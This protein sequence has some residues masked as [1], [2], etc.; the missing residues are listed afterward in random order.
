MHRYFSPGKMPVGAW[1]GRLPYKRGSQELDSSYRESFSTAKSDLIMASH[2]E[3]R[4][5]VRRD[6][7][8]ERPDRAG[9][10]QRRPII[11]KND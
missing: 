5:S 1:P 8:P 9:R 4:R 2:S 6:V 11:P 7:K 3:F 10:R